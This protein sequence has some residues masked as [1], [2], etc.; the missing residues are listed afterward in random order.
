MYKHLCISYKYLDD[1]HF[2]IMVTLV[3]NKQPIPPLI[4]LKLLFIYGASLHSDCQQMYKKFNTDNKKL[5]INLSPHKS[6]N[7]L[8]YH[9]L[10]SLL[11]SWKG[12]HSLLS[13]SLSAILNH[14][15]IKCKTFLLGCIISKGIFTP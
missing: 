8:Y 4:C 5:L 13:L 3:T 12:E 2:L 11:F 9:L 1:M 6:E 7:T 10:Y 14:N 15:S